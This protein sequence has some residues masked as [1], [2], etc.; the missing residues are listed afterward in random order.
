MQLVTEMK[1]V[2]MGMQVGTQLVFN[3]SPSWYTV[4]PSVIYVLIH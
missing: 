2:T 3:Y 1:R 4:S